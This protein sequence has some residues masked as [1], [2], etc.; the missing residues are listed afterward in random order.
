MRADAKV[1]RGHAEREPMDLLKMIIGKT[2]LKEMET[3]NKKEKDLIKGIAL[4][5]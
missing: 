3:G 5:E 4:V 1:K 2:L